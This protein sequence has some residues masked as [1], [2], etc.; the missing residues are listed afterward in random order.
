MSWEFEAKGHTGKN[1]YVS[2]K[3]PHT[4]LHLLLYNKIH[5]VCNVF[6][7]FRS[8]TLLGMKYEWFVV[9]RLTRIWLKITW[10]AYK[11][12]RGRYLASPHRQMIIGTRA[13]SKPDLK[14][15]WPHR[16]CL[17]QIYSKSG[18]RESGKEPSISEAKCGGFDFIVQAFRNLSSQFP[19]RVWLLAPVILTSVSGY[20]V[21]MS[22]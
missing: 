20:V 6:N 16:N 2:S 19:I 10:R 15:I 8:S 4:L 13:F 1:Q 5:S 21:D 12:P 18:L 3:E 22:I 11:V 7:P 14:D 17:W 9:E